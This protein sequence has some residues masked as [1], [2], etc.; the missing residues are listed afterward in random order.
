MPKP[1]HM[2]HS[3]LSAWLH[4][5]KSYQ[6]KR[7]LDAPGKPSIWLVAGVALHDTFFSINQAEVGIL[8]SLDAV[9]DFDSN[10]REATQRVLQESG[11]PLEEWRKAG[12]VTKDKPNK[13]DWDWWLTEGKRQVV[14]YQRFLKSSGWKLLVHDEKLMAEFETTA[15]FGGLV[16]KGF[17]DAIMY[18]PNGQLRCIDYKSGTRVPASKTQLGLYS[19]ALKRTL[20]LEVN[21]GAYFM[22]RKG[23]MTEE[24]DLNR[25]TP[26]YFDAIF[27]R[28]KIALDNDIFIPNPGEACHMCDV[29]DYC[30]AAGGGLSW[31]WD[32]DHPQYTSINLE[33]MQHVNN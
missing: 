4:C 16:V 19:A 17:L 33:E 6:L 5:G 8:D 20:G 11:I 29:S 7:V 26:E 25:Y 31:Q 9:K 28:A 18:N 32:P 24:F 1:E 2:S 27:S 22:T 3:Q 10:Y 23:E 13:E 14:D 15:E 12:R 30:Y 21:G